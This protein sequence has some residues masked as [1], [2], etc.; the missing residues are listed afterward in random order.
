M[1]GKNQQVST[2]VILLVFKNFILFSTLIKAKLMDNHFLKC[3]FRLL[4][5]VSISILYPLFIQNVF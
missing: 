2:P 1:S 5:R 4:A 3:P